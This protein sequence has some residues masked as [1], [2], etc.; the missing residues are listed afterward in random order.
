MLLLPRAGDKS[1]LVLGKLEPSE[2]KDVFCSR[3][4]LHADSSMK[5][6]NFN[7]RSDPHMDI[8]AQLPGSLPGSCSTL[9]CTQALVDFLKMI[10]PGTKVEIFDLYKT[11]GMEML[12]YQRNTTASLLLINGKG[13]CKL[14]NKALRAVSLV[15]VLYSL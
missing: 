9:A 15:A 6:G 7:H 4:K 3:G 14:S 8:S 10:C 13:K 12:K 5:Q 1:C 11:K 2:W